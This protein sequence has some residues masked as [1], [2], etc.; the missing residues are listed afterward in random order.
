LLTQ[1]NAPAGICIALLPLTSGE[2]LKKNSIHV[3]LFNRVTK[4]AGI[5]FKVK[6]LAS[7]VAGSTASLTSTTKKVA[8]NGLWSIPPQGVLV[9]EQGAAV[10][11]DTPLS[12]AMAAMI[13]IVARVIEYPFI[14]VRH[15][16]VKRKSGSSRM[17]KRILAPLS[18]RL[19]S[20][21]KTAP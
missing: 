14:S 21:A 20:I 18:M 11:D 19:E 4:F 10:S 16:R 7:T 8:G 1:L 2:V 12:N 5:P 6:S 15:S 17:P 13:N 9:T 3:L